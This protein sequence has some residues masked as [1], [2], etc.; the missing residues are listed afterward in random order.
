MDKFLF[1]ERIEKELLQNT[2]HNKLSI[3]KIA[4]T[5]GI[6]DKTQVKELTELAI[7]RRARAIA[8]TPETVRDRFFKI[9]DLYYNQ[10]NLSHRTSQSILLQQYSTPSTPAPTWAADIGWTGPTG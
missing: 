9:V 10:V 8:H 3:E 7:V 1:V 4:A 2:K 6:T 5:Y